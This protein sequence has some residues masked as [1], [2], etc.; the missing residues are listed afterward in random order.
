MNRGY[1]QPLKKVS[2]KLLPDQGVG[3]AM[4]CLM[5]ISHQDY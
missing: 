2:G 4:L 5:N 1:V 3:R